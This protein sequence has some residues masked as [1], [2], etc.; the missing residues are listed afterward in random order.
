V[1]AKDAF[2]LSVNWWNSRMQT[3]LKAFNKLYLKR[4]ISDPNTV[5]EL[6]SHFHSKNNILSKYI[7]EEKQLRTGHSAHHPIKGEHPI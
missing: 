6:L 3:N 4:E 2:E 5:Q 1:C 7:E